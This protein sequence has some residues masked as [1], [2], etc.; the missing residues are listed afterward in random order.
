MEEAHGRHCR[1]AHAPQFP[2]MCVSH[3]KKKNPQNQNH[4]L[5]TSFAG[6]SRLIFYSTKILDAHWNQTKL[7]AGLRKGVEGWKIQIVLL[8]LTLGPTTEY[9]SPLPKDQKTLHCRL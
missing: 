4:W 2:K 6:L 5:I 3:E 9:T 8:S 1:S 7:A